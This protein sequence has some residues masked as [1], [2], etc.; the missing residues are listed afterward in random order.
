MTVKGVKLKSE[1]FFQV[2]CGVL[3]LRR[4]TFG[5]G[6]FRL[7]PVWIGLNLVFTLLQEF[8]PQNIHILQVKQQ[9]KKTR[10][11][12]TLFVSQRFF[13]EHVFLVK[14]FLIKSVCSYLIQKYRCNDQI[15]SLPHY[16]PEVIPFPNR[17]TNKLKVS[18]KK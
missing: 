6:G 12:K 5:G 2:S 11:F 16:R 9:D 14:E 4:K 3:E 10:A 18:E 17:S 13:S 1:G 15:G 7:A 8:V